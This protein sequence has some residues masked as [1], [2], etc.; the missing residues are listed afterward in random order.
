MNVT[1]YQ[2]FIKV[3]AEV[4]KESIAKKEQETKKAE[5]CCRTSNGNPSK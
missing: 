1:N 4:I 2:A 5:F 3:V